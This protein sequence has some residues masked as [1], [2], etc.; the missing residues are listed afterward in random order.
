MGFR[1]LGDLRPSKPNTEDPPQLKVTDKIRNWAPTMWNWWQAESG[2]PWMWG[3]TRTAAPAWS[4]CCFFPI[5]SLALTQV[6]AGGITEPRGKAGQWTP[7]GQKIESVDLS[8]LPER[9]G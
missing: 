7:S 2:G 5:S 8:E 1:F 9:L 4:S 3:D 6:E